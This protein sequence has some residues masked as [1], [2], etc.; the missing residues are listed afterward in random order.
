MDYCSFF[1]LR[2]RDTQK[3]SSRKLQKHVKNNKRNFIQKIIKFVLGLY[4]I[5]V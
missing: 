5:V 2:K 3:T 1:P 4:A